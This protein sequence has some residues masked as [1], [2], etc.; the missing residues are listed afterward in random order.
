[1]KFDQ[2]AW[3][4]RLMGT[5]EAFRFWRQDP[6]RFPAGR[7]E[8]RLPVHRRVKQT[9][10]ACRPATPFRPRPRRSR[11]PGFRGAE[12]SG[13]VV[14]SVL[15]KKRIRQHGAR[16][17]DPNDLTVGSSA[18]AGRPIG[19][20]TTLR[21][22]RN[23]SYSRAARGLYSRRSS[24]RKIWP[25]GAPQSL[26][27]GLLDRGVRIPPAVARTFSTAA[28]KLVRDCFQR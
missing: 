14:L 4:R 17:S 1:V 13:P 10:P 7:G 18:Y 27:S 15:F 23:S 9:G 24:D 11:H 26:S 28:L 21:C 25:I 16:S 22:S 5:G 6:K 19:L 8:L 3:W 20:D 2:V 12:A